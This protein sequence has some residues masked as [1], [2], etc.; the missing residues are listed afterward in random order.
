MSSVELAEPRASR[1]VSPVSA[2]KREAAVEIIE[3]LD[4]IESLWR[5]FEDQAVRSPYQR[6]DWIQPF[7]KAFA[8][9]EPFRARVVVLRDDS[10]RPRLLLPLAIRRRHGMTVAA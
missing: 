5:S 10:G 4:A 6:F 2:K 1:T 9:P 8:E 3:D 7:V